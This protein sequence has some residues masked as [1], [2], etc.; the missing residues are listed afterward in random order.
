M[1]RLPHRG[2]GAGAEIRL[3]LPPPPEAKDAEAVA[4]SVEIV[5]S[6]N[7]KL[8]ESLAVAQAAVQPERIAATPRPGEVLIR[9]IG[10]PAPALHRQDIPRDAFQ[11]M[12]LRRVVYPQYSP[13]T[14]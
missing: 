6:R 7:R 8:V 2:D 10:R 14:D 3:F 9:V 12:P 1:F 4:V 13:R 11:A 5:L